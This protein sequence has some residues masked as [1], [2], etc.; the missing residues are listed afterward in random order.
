MYPVRSNIN[1][2]ANL[3]LKVDNLFGDNVNI[4]CF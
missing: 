4:I 2:M 1:K 3:E